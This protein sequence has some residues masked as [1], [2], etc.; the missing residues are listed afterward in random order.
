[1]QLWVI[2]MTVGRGLS[3]WTGAGL[4]SDNTAFIM[5]NSAASLTG[6][7]GACFQFTL[8]SNT[9][10]SATVAPSQ[11]PGCAAGQYS[12]GFALTLTATSNAGLGFVGWTSSTGLAGSSLTPWTVYMPN[13]PTSVT[14]NFAA[15]YALTLTLGGSTTNNLIT[16]PT[17]SQGCATGSF[18][19]GTTIQVM[20]APNFVASSFSGASST[21]LTVVSFTMP[22]ATYTYA[23]TATLTCGMV[24]TTSA[25]IVITTARTINY[26]MW[27]G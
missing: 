25:T 4:S 5:P 13:A 24:V 26:Q 16:V 17:N 2:P 12:A 1:L 27:G 11:T 19:A 15:C 6:I 18:A 3:Y 14:A 10:G 9:G 23:A 20:G 7:V 21:S 8:S 22:A